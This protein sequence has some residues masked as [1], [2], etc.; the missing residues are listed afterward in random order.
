MINLYLVEIEELMH[1]PITTFSEYSLISENRCTTINTSLD[2]HLL[3]L[4]GCSFTT[5]YGSL[6][7]DIGIQQE[8]YSLVYRRHLRTSMKVDLETD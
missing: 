2:L 3:L 4:L 1:G 8:D 6:K 7:N 5:A